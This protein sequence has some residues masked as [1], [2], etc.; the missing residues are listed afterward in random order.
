M[1]SI[2]NKSLEELNKESLKEDYNKAV[3]GTYRAVKLRLSSTNKIHTTK[4]FKL[5]LKEEFRNKGFVYVN[6]SDRTSV[7]RTFMTIFE[8][9]E[10]SALDCKRIS[11]FLASKK[12]SKTEIRA[13][14]FYL[15]YKYKS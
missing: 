2:D 7:V 10:Y 6:Y 8:K 9:K 15:G 12:L 3:L 4:P 1:I 13:I 14:M 5:F 11:Y